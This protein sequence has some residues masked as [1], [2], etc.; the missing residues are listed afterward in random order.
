MSAL[1]RKLSGHVWIPSSE[2]P[3]ISLSEVE[4][5]RAELWAEAIQ[6]LMNEGEKKSVQTGRIA[7]PG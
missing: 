2:E 4:S 3:D 5:S 1:A 7:T 6:T